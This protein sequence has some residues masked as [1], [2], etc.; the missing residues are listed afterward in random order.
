MANKPGKKSKKPWIILS[1]ILFI[2][3]GIPLIVLGLSFIGRIDPDSV[4][5]DSFDLY[6]SVPNPVDLTEKVLSHESLPEILAVQEL[7]PLVPVLADFESSGVLGNRFVRFA[8]K[9]R[10]DAASYEEGRLLA[11]WNMG[12]CSPL[13]R[14]LPAIAGRLTIPN[15]YY[16]QA[17]KNSR[18]E[19]RMDNGT[20]FYIGPYKNLLI[21]SNNSALFESVLQGTSRDRDIR[22]SS[23]KDFF[24]RDY[25]VAFL[26]S[27]SALSSLVGT[28]DPN[29]A[30]T[31]NLL[32]FPG[33]VEASLRVLPKQLELSIVTPLDSGSPALKTIIER[34]SAAAGL[35]AIIPENTQYL[36]LLSAGPL[37]EILDAGSAVSGAEFDRTYSQADSAAK[38]LFGLSL[39]DILC[40][41]TGSEFAVFGL[42]GRPNPVIA[43]EIRDEAKRREIFNKIFQSIFIEENINLNL[44]GNRIPRI[45]VPGFLAVF[46]K[47]LNV[48]VPS[49]YYT[50]HDNYLLVSESAETLLAAV[51]AIRGNAVLPKTELWRTLA[52]NSAGRPASSRGSG[53][54]N[55]FSLYYSLD[56]SLPFFLR[57]NSMAASVLKLYRQGLVRLSLEQRTARISL[58]V[59]PGAGKGIMPVPGFPVETGGRTDNRLYG[60]RSGQESRLLL[61]RDNA[62][63]ALN[64]ADR[65]FSEMPNP[66]GPGSPGREGSLLYLIPAEDENFPVRNAGGD[67]GIAWVV[68]SQ[69]RVS[70]VNKNMESLRGFPVITGVRLSSAPAV[71][72]GKLY[73]SGE[74]GYVHIVDKQGAVSRW[75]TRFTPPLLSPP[76]FLEWHNSVYAASYPK[77]FLGELWLQDLA[78]KALP[79]WPVFASGIAFGSPLLFGSNGSGVSNNSNA[80]L[81][82]AFITQAGELTV[83]AE[84]AVPLPTFPLSLEGVFYVQPVFDGEFL[85]LLNDRGMLYQ[86]S[87]EGEILSQEIPRLSVK[88]SG[89]ITTADVDGDGIGEIFF[90]GEGNVLYGYK[91]NF[92]SLDGFPLPVRGRPVIA[93]INGDGKIE[94]AGAGMDNRIYMWQFRK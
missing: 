41:W 64:P 33:A 15:L 19:Y 8:A 36:T 48:E 90:S 7:A 94:F 39:D 85:W 57:G 52:G 6:A 29:I 83:Y 14:F 2:I 24:A 51:N 34:N 89:F 30:S 26:L 68:N 74:D 87:L 22:K 93:D 47:W 81:L 4:I 25:D 62:A 5:P 56:R 69:G 28:A 32:R 18:F 71:Q 60:V 17:G 55:S 31:V 80:R 10:L 58:S 35:T 75:E 66:G 92:M 12:I 59:I 20:V 3:I 84:D 38:S 77:S 91:R 76:S 72:G 53:D 70:L 65:T 54:L 40:S 79:G 9:G 46:L 37:R 78:G 43:V 61:V 73:L 86:I 82:M 23:A 88:E 50:V 16:V 11:S 1:I 44:D 45:Q 27:S 67:D 42:E 13:L 63:L 49:P 21:L